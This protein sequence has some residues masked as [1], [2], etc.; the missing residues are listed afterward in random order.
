LFDEDLAMLGGLKE[1]NK[2]NEKYRL[3]GCDAAWIL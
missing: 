3:L 2:I 1:R